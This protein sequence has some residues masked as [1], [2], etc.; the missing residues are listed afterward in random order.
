MPKKKKPGITLR[1]VIE[2]VQAMKGELKQDIQ[3]VEYTLT[4]K[5]D[6]LDKKVDTLDRKVG[7]LDVKVDR[8]HSQL[9]GQLDEI[10]HRLD[11]L[12]VGEIP[13]LKKAVGIGQ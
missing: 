13:A 8:H 10:D 6:T 7:A 4:N 5:I 12:E 2:H 3:D 9:K 11:T 1:T